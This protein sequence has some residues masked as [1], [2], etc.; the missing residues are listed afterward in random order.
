MD[1]HRGCADPGG[2]WRNSDSLRDSLSLRSASCSARLRRSGVVRFDREDLDGLASLLRSRWGL[3]VPAASH[4]LGSLPPALRVPPLPLGPAF[5]RGRLHRGP[6]WSTRLGLGS[7]PPV[8]SAR[9][10]D[11]RPEGRRQHRSF[12]GRDSDSRW[13]FVSSF[14]L[15]VEHAE[16]VVGQ[17]E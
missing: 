1:R 11:G 16:W 7:S 10:A 13:L 8:A 3:R 5:D 17:F 12:E 14:L 6:I 15:Q 9:P 2:L 4:F